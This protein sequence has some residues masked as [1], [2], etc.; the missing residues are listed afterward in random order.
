M[1]VGSNQNKIK[2]KKIKRE[3]IKERKSIELVYIQSKGY[4]KI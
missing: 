4:N 2:I 1:L 3:N